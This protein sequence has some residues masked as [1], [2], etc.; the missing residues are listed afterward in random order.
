MKRTDKTPAQFLNL[1]QGDRNAEAIEELLQ[2]AYPEPPTEL[3]RIRDIRFGMGR[4]AK[5]C[6]KFFDNVDFEGWE[7]DQECV[8]MTDPD[9]LERCK[10]HVSFFPPE[11]LGPQ[12]DILLGDF[13]NLTIKKAAPL[14]E[15]VE[16]Y[17]PRFL[18]FTDSAPS[19]LHLN[20]STYGLARKSVADYLRLYRAT[21]PGYKLTHSIQPHHAV[22]ISLWTKKED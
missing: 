14:V 1:T 13:N 17:R 15:A 4:W 21:L 19:K 10:V 20:L 7:H 9:V 3:V 5:T 2:H 22:V 8:D 18:I 11:E 6:L 12:P 16:L